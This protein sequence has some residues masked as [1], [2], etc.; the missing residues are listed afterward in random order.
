MQQDKNYLKIKRMKRPFLIIGFSLLAT[1]LWSGCKHSQAEDPE[2]STFVLSDTML[3]NIRIDTARMQPVMNELRLSGNRD[4]RAKGRLRI[5]R[6]L[7]GADDDASDLRRASCK[8]V[9]SRR[10]LLYRTAVD[11]V[12][13]RLD[14]RPRREGIILAIPALGALEL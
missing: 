8:P 5:R 2:K 1:V 11:L 10:L 4:Q 6:G 7:R 14:R 9:E 13:D 12:V 3:E